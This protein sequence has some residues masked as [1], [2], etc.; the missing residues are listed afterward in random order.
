LE[1]S[2]WQWSRH[3]LLF[4]AYIRL[5]P[6]TGVATSY[7]FAASGFVPAGLRPVSHVSSHQWRAVCNIP[8]VGRQHVLPAVFMYDGEVATWIK[9][10]F[11]ETFFLAGTY[12]NKE[13]L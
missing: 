7:G 4:H 3:P 13:R 11:G 5:L 9:R 1:Q 12:S 2:C 10:N 8:R 6:C